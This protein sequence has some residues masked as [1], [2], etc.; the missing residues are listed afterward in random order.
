MVK[1]DIRNSV[2]NSFHWNKVS[3]EDEKIED[4][5]WKLEKKSE[6][7]SI[8]TI[9]NE[10]FCPQVKI[11]HMEHELTKLG[12]VNSFFPP[13]LT[14]CIEAARICPIIEDWKRDNADNSGAWVDIHKVRRKWV[15]SV[16][17]FSDLEITHFH[18]ARGRKMQ[19]F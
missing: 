19:P 12:I 11:F 4:F 13:G 15:S 14:I 2:K 6:I 10:D 9:P 8:F 17:N 1:I 18:R 16:G 7:F 5:I 3:D